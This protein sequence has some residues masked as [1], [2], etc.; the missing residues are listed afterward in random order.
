MTKGEDILELSDRVK[1]KLNCWEFMLCGRE[2]GGSKAKDLGVCP[3]SRETKLHN[4]HDGRNAGRACWVVAGSLCGGTR[5][6][7][8]AD[9]F[10]T[11]EKCEFFMKVK[12]E[13]GARFNFASV[14]LAR[15]KGDN[16]AAAVSNNDRSSV[17]IRS[18]GKSKL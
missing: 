16:G 11:C 3:V 9:K 10:V 15:F 8:F 1:R 4:V 12:Q 5:Q 2:I 6:G 18:K 13:I 7:T 14:L 17:S